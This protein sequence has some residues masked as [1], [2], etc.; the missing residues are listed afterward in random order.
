MSVPRL[1]TGI[2]VS[3]QIRLC[4]QKMIPAVII[5]RGDIDAGGVLIKIN[6]LGHGCTVLARVL[7]GEGN[8]VWMEVAGGIA[9][10][11][12]Q[13]LKME[14][15]SDDYIEREINM[16]PDIWVMEI[17]DKN[18]EYTPDGEIIN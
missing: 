13:H 9:Q 16:D 4:D 6:T 10:D 7:D 15:K 12:D 3:A 1:K 18:A 11:K 8:R 2:W 17:E 14:K 5:K